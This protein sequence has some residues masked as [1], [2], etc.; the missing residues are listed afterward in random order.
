MFRNEQEKQIVLVEL[1]LS[2]GQFMK[3]KL[4]IAPAST[5]M[6]TLNGDSGFLEFENAEGAILVI[7]KS[8]IVSVTSL[9]M[10]RVNELPKIGMEGSDPH[11]VLGIEPGAEQDEIHHA[12]VEL[13]KIYHPDRFA[14][15][16]L[17][18][19]VETY[20]NARIR[21]INAAYHFLTDRGRR[22]AA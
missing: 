17:P 8:A 1:S 5:L 4:F 12:Y 14:G 16:R 18:S 6:R 20:L 2:D 22:R 3:G 11:R 13:S 10:P 7:S 9:T 15:L 21:S 19:E